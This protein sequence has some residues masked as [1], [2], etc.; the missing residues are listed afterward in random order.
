MTRRIGLESVA[1]SFSAMQAVAKELREENPK[2]NTQA[3]VAKLLGVG[4]QTVSD[5]FGTNT[6]SGNTSDPTSDARTKIAPTAHPIIL[7]RVDEG[8]SRAQVAA[9]YGVSQQQVS[10][11]IRKETKQA[12][13]KK[14]RRAA[15]R[16][17]AGDL[18]GIHHVASKAGLPR[19]CF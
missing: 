18:R 9:D 4:Q 3:R 14:Q 8:E 11:I 5:W 10:N 7:E 19:R 2:K 6:G 13:A 1:L 16:K 12:E 15:V 17:L